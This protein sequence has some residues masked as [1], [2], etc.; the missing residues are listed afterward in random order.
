MV[1][2]T[3]LVHILRFD[4]KRSLCQFCQFFPFFFFFSLDGKVIVRPLEHHY[5]FKTNLKIQKTG[6]MLIGWGGNNG[7][8]VTAGVLANKLG[9]S[10]NTK[11]G[12]QQSNY[13]GSLTQATTIFIGSDDEGKAVHGIFYHPHI[14]MKKK[15]DFD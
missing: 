13:Y 10:W 7:T 11:E 3:V 4:S 15:T 12:T 9:L 14:F 2:V 8:T 5:E 6:V 1:A